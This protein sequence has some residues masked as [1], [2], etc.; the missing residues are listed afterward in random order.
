MRAASGA[1]EGVWI[2]ADSYEP[3]IKVI[4]DIAPVGLC[5]SGLIDLLS[6]MLKAGIM[7]SSGKLTDVDHLRLRKSNG[8][9]EY[10]VAWK[11]EAGIDE[12]ISIT[13][14][15]IRE[16][17]KGKAAIFSGSYIA[18][19]QLGVDADDVEHVYMAGAFG[20]YINRESAQNIGM[21]P[22]FNML[23]VEQVGNAAGTGARMALLSREAREEAKT[24]RD[25]VEYIELSTHPDY[26]KAYLDALMFP[27]KNLSLF[28]ET[29]KKLKETHWDKVRL[30]H[31]D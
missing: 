4:D 30:L 28:P 25:K 13:Q 12:D 14:K 16:L 27:H 24:L 22:E 10:V 5:G 23:A 20:T 19:R 2:D 17:Q 6:E 9:K 31:S 26:N 15:D 21:I 7:D 11:G 8:I 18:M 1:I 3:R 29:V